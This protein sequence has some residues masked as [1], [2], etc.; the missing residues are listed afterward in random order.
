MPPMLLTAPTA[1]TAPATKPRTRRLPG[2]HLPPVSP[3]G[4]LLA[5]IV[6]SPVA[7]LDQAVRFADLCQLIQ[8]TWIFPALVA[9]ETF[10]QPAL[11]HAA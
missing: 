4:L 10:T 3:Q 2:K 1:I 7:P 11:A 5:R 8:R 9:D 6:V